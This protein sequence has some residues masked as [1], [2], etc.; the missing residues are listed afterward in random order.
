MNLV[1]HPRDERDESPLDIAEPQRQT[2]ERS[3]ALMRRAAYEQAPIG[4]VLQTADGTLR[5]IN[6]T[7]CLMLG[8]TEVEL[9]T[10]TVPELINP[11]EV[12]RDWEQYQ[13]M[14]AGRLESFEI[15][16]RTFWRCGRPIWGKLSLSL[17][18]DPAGKVEWLISEIEELVPGQSQEPDP[19][20]TSQRQ[21][22]L[23][24]MAHLGSWEMDQ[25][26]HCT[27]SDHFYQILGLVPDTANPS[28]E[29]LLQA[30]CADDK[31]A[32]ENTIHE[33]REQQNERQIHCRL[34]RADGSLR[35]VLIKVR[36][37]AQ[38]AGLHKLSGTLLDVT[39]QWEKARLM[40]QASILLTEQ[41]RQLD[42]VLRM[43]TH[44][45]RAP[46]A[47][48]IG[49]AHMLDEA[50]SDSEKL[51]LQGLLLRCLEQGL[52]NLDEM[53]AQTYHQMPDN[54]ELELVS[55]QEALDR[56]LIVLATAFRS[57][58]AKIET[59]FA[60]PELIYSPVYLNSIVYNLVSNAL[61]YRDPER[62]L[63]LCLRS[64][65]EAERTILEVEDNGIGI[66]L[67]KY[68]QRIFKLHEVFTSQ[69]DSHGVGLY[70][71]HNQ[72]ESLGGSIG[73][74]SQPG[75]GTSFRIRF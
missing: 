31:A 6:R 62:P 53:V 51:E 22:I 27:W 16:K 3:A 64:R 32:L 14:L 24:D 19:D 37:P 10:L 70:L 71:T 63:R 30:I 36:V 28:L 74:T 58:Q 13:E 20:R 42:H 38:E 67:E 50:A 44:N 18:R 61:K 11:E 68:G 49:L 17:V 45:L 69:A 7:L 39:E 52:S 25:S 55:F 12:A 47:N 54:L 65:S 66:D 15:E 48:A 33:A 2:L 60:C 34:L 59:D 23:E 41:N 21:D 8:Y 1:L 75:Q 9:L 29:L 4:K 57:S 26:G 5:A 35:Q 73:I 43:A 56:A 72:I 40:E 46:I